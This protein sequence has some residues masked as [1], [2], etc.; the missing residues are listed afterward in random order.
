M[1]WENPKSAQSRKPFGARAEESLAKEMAGWNDER[2]HELLKIAATPIDFDQL[3]ADRVLRKHGGRYELLDLA[4]LP[5]HAR[6]K[7]RVIGTSSKTKNPV[8]SFSKPSKQL[9]RQAKKMGLLPPD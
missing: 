2:L 5:E 4:R 6:R 7:I 3:I 9:V 8:I 1:T